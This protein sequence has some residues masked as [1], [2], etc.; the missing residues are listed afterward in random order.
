MNYLVPLLFGLGILAVGF[1]LGY[2]RGVVVGE[3]M[4]KREFI[5]LALEDM[6]NKMSDLMK[7]MEERMQESESE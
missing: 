6:K 3:I 5:R 1:Y 7:E 2:R 4:A